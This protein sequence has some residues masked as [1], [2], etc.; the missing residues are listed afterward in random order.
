M[1]MEAMDS[2]EKKTRRYNF[3]T[4]NFS[5]QTPSSKYRSPNLQH[6]NS[7]EYDYVFIVCMKNEERAL[8][9][10]VDV[11]VGGFLQPIWDNRV[12]NQD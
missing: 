5:I 9:Y 7:L 11:E 1:M 3:S 12:D 10:I 4:T 2:W 8:P 6:N